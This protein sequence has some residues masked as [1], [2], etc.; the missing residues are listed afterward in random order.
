MPRPSRM[1]ARQLRALYL[2]LLTTD[3]WPSLWTPRDQKSGLD[4]SKAWVLARLPQLK[5]GQCEQLY[6][7]VTSHCFQSGTAEVELKKGETI[8]LTL[9][10][11]Y[12]DNCDEK[13]LWLDYKNITKVVQVGSHIYVDDGLI[14]LKVKEV[15][16]STNNLSVLLSFCLQQLKYFFC[17]SL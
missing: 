12:K 13:I 7:Q 2:D 3:Q 10:D 1:S 11:Q 14:S 15:G 5:W 4:L 8:K 6:P 9:D 16:K 17:A